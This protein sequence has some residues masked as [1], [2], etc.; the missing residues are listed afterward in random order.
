MT[1]PWI[2]PMCNRVNAPWMAHCTCKIEYVGLTA[3]PIVAPQMPF[4][5]VSKILDPKDK[6]RCYCNGVIPMVGDIVCNINDCNGK[7]RM[8]V[9]ILDDGSIVEIDDYGPAKTS[10]LQLVYRAKAKVRI[11]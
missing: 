1:A 3:A 7:H 10:C 2:C 5:S 9:G 11:E 6:E 4:Q 8:V